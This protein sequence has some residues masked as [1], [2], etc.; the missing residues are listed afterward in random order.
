MTLC[1]LE[2]PVAYFMKEIDGSLAKPPLKF[3]GSVAKLG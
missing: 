1:L 2:E 3:N